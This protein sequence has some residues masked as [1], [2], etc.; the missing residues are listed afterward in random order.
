MTMPRYLIERTFA[1]GLRFPIDG[2]G[3]TAAAGII[4]CNVRAGR[5][6][7]PLLCQ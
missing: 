7:G 4:A 6:L 3:R 1:D 5:D 2:T